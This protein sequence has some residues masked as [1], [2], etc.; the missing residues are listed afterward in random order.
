MFLSSGIGVY[1]QN[2][3]PRL[4][5]FIPE[6]AITLLGSVAVGDKLA[7]CMPRAKIQTLT[8]NIYTVRE[9]WE[10]R[11]EGLQHRGLWWSPHFN[12]PLGYRGPLV[13]TI[14]DLF[15]LASA[16]MRSNHLKRAYASLM[17]AAVRRRARKII[18]VSRFTAGEFQRLVG[19]KADQLEVIHNGIDSSWL[20][21]IS[22]V[23]PQKTP[24]FLFVGNLKP[25]KNVQGLIRAFAQIVERLPH[26]LVIVG[27]RS[28]FITSDSGAEQLA[29]AVGSRVK[30]TGFVE[31]EELRQWYRHAAALVFPSF[32]EGFGLPPLEAMAVRCPV[33]ASNAASLPEVCGDAAL[34]CDPSDIATI[35]QAMLRIASEHDLRERLIAAGQ[36]K[37]TEYSW[38]DSAARTAAVLQR[39]LEAA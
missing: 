1:L 11:R 27:Q 9:Q 3:L 30:F 20:E 34:Y 2:I 13:V 31:L 22:E 17:F 24:Y 19:A 39:A 28:G 16:E 38:T 25:N 32:Y 4:G 15:H 18:C 35:A 23:R 7:A 26:D 21:P 8:S 36:Q 10:M 33:I 29:R 14:H 5:A 6:E 37:V 12:I